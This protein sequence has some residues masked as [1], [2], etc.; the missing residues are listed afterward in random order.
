ML[1]FGMRYKWRLIV[2]DLLDRK[3]LCVRPILTIPF[4]LLALKIY[5]FEVKHDLLILYN[6]MIINMTMSWVF[7]PETVT[8]H[9]QK[10]I[11]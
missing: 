2:T 7:V 3:R 4:I 9:C 1:F 6:V 5:F 11:T 8:G 10:A